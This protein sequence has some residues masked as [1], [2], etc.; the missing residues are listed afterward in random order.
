MKA[1]NPECIYDIRLS[2]QKIMRHE[3]DPVLLDKISSCTMMSD[4]T[5]CSK[6]KMQTDR[7][8]PQSTWIIH[9]TKICRIAFLFINNICNDKLL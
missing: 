3:R 7:K 1:L 5:Q 4:K 8:Q 6:R 9:G 2:M